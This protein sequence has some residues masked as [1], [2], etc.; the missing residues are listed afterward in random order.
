MG[1]LG[2]NHLSG[3]WDELGRCRDISHVAEARRASE[4]IFEDIIVRMLRSYRKEGRLIGY[5]MVIKPK[6]G[7]SK[8]IYVNAKVND[9]DVVKKRVAVEVVY[10]TKYVGN[11]YWVPLQWVEAAYEIAEAPPEPVKKVA[12]DFEPPPLVLEEEE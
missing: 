9:V 7:P 8:R 5:V 3:L 2:G 1:D 4:V 10:P 12:D 11:K 6:R